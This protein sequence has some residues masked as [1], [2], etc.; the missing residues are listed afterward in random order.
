[1]KL[2][3]LFSLGL[4]YHIPQV[5]NEDHPAV[6][7][8]HVQLEKRSEPQVTNAA[9]EV[10]E[11]PVA[12]IPSNTTNPPDVVEE[13]ADK[14]FGPFPKSVQQFLDEHGDKPI[15]NLTLHRAPIFVVLQVLIEGLDRNLRPK[16]ETYG[17]D[18]FWHV[19]LSFNIDGRTYGMEKTYI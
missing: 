9:P 6:P 2:L 10:V 8:N 14:V 4:C 17:Y 19:W 7:P 3:L 16:L 13:L 18:N 1:M 12:S 11:T 5:V 15:A